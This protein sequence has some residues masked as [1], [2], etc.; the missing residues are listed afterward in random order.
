MNLPEE[1]WHLLDSILA[2]A[3]SSLH[4][5]SVIL[6]IVVVLGGFFMYKKI[7]SNEALVIRLLALI[8]D[9][10]GKKKE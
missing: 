1:L 3:T 5:A 4:W 10:I 8:E 9:L 7:A 2:G 6:L